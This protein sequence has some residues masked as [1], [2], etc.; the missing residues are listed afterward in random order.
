[1]IGLGSFVDGLGY[2]ISMLSD[3]LVVQWTIFLLGSFLLCY[4]TQQKSGVALLSLGYVFAFIV[5]SILPMGIMW[6][7]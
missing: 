5:G 7:V 4:C 6:L 1:M 3:L 2:L